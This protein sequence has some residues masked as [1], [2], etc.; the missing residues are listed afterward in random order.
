MPLVWQPPK[1]F[2]EHNNVAVYHTYKHDSSASYWYTTNPADDNLNSPF[3][4]HEAGQFDVRDLPRAPDENS[5][6]TFRERHATR[7]KAAIDS[8]DLLHDQ[9]VPNKTSKGG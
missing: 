3:Q 6:Q 4:G 1:L 9:T 7:I 2:L 5:A 8:G